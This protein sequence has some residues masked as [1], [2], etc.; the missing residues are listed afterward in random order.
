[1]PDCDAKGNEVVAVNDGKLFDILTAPEIER[2]VFGAVD[3]NDLT[4]F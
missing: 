2:F 3:M 1:L 4:W